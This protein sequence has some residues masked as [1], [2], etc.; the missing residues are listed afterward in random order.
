MISEQELDN[1]LSSTDKLFSNIYAFSLDPCDFGGKSHSGCAIAHQDLLE[2]R[3]DFLRELRNTMSAWVYSK[4]K[5]AALFNEALANRNLDLQN[6]TAQLN[7]LVRS[8]FRRGYPAGQFGELLLFNLL[9]RFYKAP[10][11]LRK[12]P[13]TT[14]PKIERHGA[15]AIHYRRSGNLNIVYLGEAKTYSS[16][17]SF[18]KA[19]GDAIES[20]YGSYL[21]FQNELNLYV[22]DDL[23]ADELLP[24]AKAV[25]ENALDD[26]VLEAVC[27][28]SYDEQTQKVGETEADLHDCIE[29]LVAKRLAAL[30]TKHGDGV[31]GPIF[32]RM[33]FYFLPF[34]GLKNLLE[35]FDK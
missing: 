29:A 33:H 16:K 23:V 9:Q 11:I 22:Y 10:P 17:N 34:W 30:K 24:V 14:N 26:F 28:I 1:L 32:R 4:N 2:R 8:K 19:V 31:N 5:F 27:I 3:V 25:K 35:E 12:M 18:S 21:G 13:L 6:A 20:T 7:E 15:D